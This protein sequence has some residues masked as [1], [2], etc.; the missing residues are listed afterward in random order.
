MKKRTLAGFNDVASTDINSSENTVPSKNTDQLNE[1][2]NTRVTTKS[3]MIDSLIENNKKQ[4]IMKG[5]VLDADV[6]KAI[7]RISK[8]KGRGFKSEFVNAVLKQVLSEKGLI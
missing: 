8:G 6:A 5:F 3:D 7:D 1:S 2:K 4:T